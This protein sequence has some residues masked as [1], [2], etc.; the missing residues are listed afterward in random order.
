MRLVIGCSRTHVPPLPFDHGTGLF[1]VDRGAGAVIGLDE[2]CV[3]PHLGMAQRDHVRLDWHGPCR[4][5]VRVRPVAWTCVCQA[6]VYEPCEGGGQGFIRRTRQ[7][8]GG[9]RVDES[10]RWSIAGSRATW[11]ALLSGGAR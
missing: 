11:A 2:A 7:L 5:P 1:H 10:H 4:T 9:H 3:S 8:K 6:T